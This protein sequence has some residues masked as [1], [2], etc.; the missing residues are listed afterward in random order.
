MRALKALASLFRCV[1]S[2]EHCVAHNCESIKIA[3][4]GPFHLAGMFC[5][6]GESRIWEWTIFSLN[7]FRGQKMYY[8]GIKIMIYKQI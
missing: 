5:L 8:L 1:D 2:I 4:A 6:L 7:L 3:C